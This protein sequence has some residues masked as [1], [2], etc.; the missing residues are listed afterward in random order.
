MKDPVALLCLDML[1]LAPI[2]RG[3]LLRK[4]LIL[5]EMKLFFMF[6]WLCFFMHRR[7]CKTAFTEKVLKCLSHIAN[8][9]RNLM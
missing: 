6:Y 4:M 8:W 1:N 5:K 2:H 3:T 7:N 9:E